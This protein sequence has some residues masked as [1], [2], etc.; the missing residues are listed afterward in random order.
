MGLDH[1]FTS[2]VISA[3][4]PDSIQTD[5]TVYFGSSGGPLVDGSGA[6]CGVITTTHSHKDISFAIYADAVLD[7]L[8]ERDRGA[9]VVADLGGDPLAGCRQLSS[10]AAPEPGVDGAPEQDFSRLGRLIE[11]GAEL[12]PRHREHP[13]ASFGS[14]GQLID[15]LFSELSPTVEDAE[16]RL[17]SG[18][19]VLA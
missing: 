15:A 6:L 18:D 16:L 2:G 8:V 7:L 10:G 4:R 17:L 19:D 3:L 9:G 13:L 12:G 11:D 1:T 14:G 5:A